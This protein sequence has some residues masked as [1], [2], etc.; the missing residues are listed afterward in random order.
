MLVGPDDPLFDR[1]FGPGSGTGA[2]PG[3]GQAHPSGARWDPISPPGLPGFQPAQPGRGNPP[4]LHPDIMQPGP[5]RS[6]TGA[7]FGFM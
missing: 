5:G 7:E 2:H 3:W 4:G 6:G 1:R